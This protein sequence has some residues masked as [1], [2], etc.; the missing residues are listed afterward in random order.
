MII[1]LKKI[2]FDTFIGNCGGYGNFRTEVAGIIAAKIL[3]KKK[4]NLLI[5]HN[6][7]KPKIW[8]YILNIIDFILSKSIKNLIFISNATKKSIIENTKLDNC[9]KKNLFI[10]YNGILLKKIKNKK[11]SYFNSNSQ[12]LKLVCLPELV[13][14][15][16]N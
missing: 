5:H 3:R 15:K 8:I 16:V 4:I 12:L 9:P 10:I 11:V 14:I 6:Y 1:I 13:N 2:S 7:S